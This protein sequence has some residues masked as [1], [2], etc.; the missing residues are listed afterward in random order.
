MDMIAFIIFKIFLFKCALFLNSHKSPI[1]GNLSLRLQVTGDTA[2]D[3]SQARVSITRNEINLGT[4]KWE[5]A[6]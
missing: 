4:D 1:A 5:G 2:G 6:S 3:N